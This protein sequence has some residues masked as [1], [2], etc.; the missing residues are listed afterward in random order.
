M[1][2]NID[3]LNGRILDL[4]KSRGELSNTLIVYSS[5]HGEMLGDHND[6]EKFT[7]Y[8]PSLCV[9]LVISGPGVKAGTSSLAL[10]QLID[11]TAT[12]L[13]YAG[14][15]PLPEMDGV[16]L[17]P[18]LEGDV[19][20]VNDYVFSGLENRGSMSQGSAHKLCNFDLI[21]DGRYKLVTQAS[22]EPALFDLD[23]D[24]TESNNIATSKP[25]ITADL[26][27]KLTEELARPL[28]SS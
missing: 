16:S 28:P 3:T 1:I 26:L 24:P 15:D 7:Y 4:L 9:P 14:A 11:L 13:D 23:K 19:E 17:R 20:E 22:E 5:D 8:H 27:S 12:F 25:E 2:E 10:T 6:W 21:W 18:V